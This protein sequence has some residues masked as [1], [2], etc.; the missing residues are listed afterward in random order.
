[1]GDTVPMLE[2]MGK[3]TMSQNTNVTRPMK[4]NAIPHL[5]QYHLI[6]ARIE[7]KKSARNLLKWFLFQ[8]KSK[9]VMMNRRKYASLKKNLSQNKSRSTY[10]QR[11]AV[12]YPKLY[13]IML[14]KCFL[15]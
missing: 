1:M 11:N 10:T 13:A 2:D 6:I 8:L 5:V 14:I 15:S 9:I 3:A 4:P 7:K 12:L